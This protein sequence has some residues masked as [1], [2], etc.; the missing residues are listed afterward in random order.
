M[1]IGSVVATTIIG[2]GAFS[3]ATSLAGGAISGAAAGTAANAQLTASQ[4]ALQAQIAARASAVSQVQGLSGMSAG[5][6]ASINQI[7]ATQSSALSASMSSIQTQQTQLNAMS[8]DVQQAGTD[9]YNLLSGQS[10]SVLAPMQQQINLQRSQM[11]NQLESQL[12]PGWATSSAGINA[13]MQFNM[14]SATTLQNAQQSAINNVASTYGSLA[15]IQSQGQ[16]GVT[17][18]TGQAY[19]ASQTANALA[20]QANQTVA[21]RG[22]N[23]TLGAMNATPIGYTGTTP[24]AGAG[25]VGA[26]NF[27]NTLSATGQSLGNAASTAGVYGS[28]L[29]NT[30]P[31]SLSSQIYASPT[32]SSPTFGQSLTS[33]S[34][35]TQPN[36]GVGGFSSETAPTAISGF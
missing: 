28:V 24:Y 31:P 27:G 12:G 36:L 1:S 35:Y 29:G 11:Q 8:P 30:S 33:G 7:M 17:N 19:G 2:A 15:G 3:A 4:Q 18:A 13:M 34:T 14:Q 10:S 9:L 21:Q 6:M 22:V 16:A 32:V 5:E 23:A 20:L 25:A 26:Q